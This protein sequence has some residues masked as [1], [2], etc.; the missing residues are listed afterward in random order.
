MRKRLDESMSSILRA[1]LL[2]VAALTLVAC[3][4]AVEEPDLAGN[5]RLEQQRER[6]GS[7]LG[8]EGISLE[9][10]GGGETS[11]GGASGIGVNEFLWRASLDTVSFLPVNSADPFGG[12]ILSDWYGSPDSPAERFKVN[13]YILGRDLRTDGLRVAVFRQVRVQDGSWRDAPVAPETVI[14]LEETILTR[15]RELRVLANATS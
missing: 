6:R 5:D 1:S 4:P 15:A 13:V 11:G 7:I 10:F 12:V 3:G 9:V 14:R 8:N 2:A